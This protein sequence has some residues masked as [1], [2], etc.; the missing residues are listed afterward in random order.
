MFTLKLDFNDAFQ[1]VEDV[2]EYD[3]VFVVEFEWC[4][5]FDSDDKAKVSGVFLFCNLPEAFDNFFYGPVS[6]YLG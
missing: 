4:L 1:F 6:S 2:L 5:S 3:L